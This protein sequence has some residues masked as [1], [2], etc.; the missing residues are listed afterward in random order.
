[1]LTKIRVDIE[2]RQKAVKIPTGLRMLIRRCCHAVLDLEGV[3]GSAQVD[4]TLVDNEL[5]HQINLEQ[6]GIDAPTDVLSFPLGENGEFDINPENGDKLIGNI[7]LSLEQAQR[8]AEDFGH[9][10]NREVGYLTVHSMFHLL[11]YDHVGG[12]LDAVHMREKEETVMNQ[13]GLSR[14][15]SYVLDE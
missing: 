10:F 8:Q 2:N 4:V 3:D 7:V 14:V 5:I 13:I 15:N 1:M 9:S 11:G 12:G 6:R